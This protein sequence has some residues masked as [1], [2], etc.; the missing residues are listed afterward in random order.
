M[1]HSQQLSIHFPG[2]LVFANGVMLQLFTGVI[3]LH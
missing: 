2:K 3:S 1:V